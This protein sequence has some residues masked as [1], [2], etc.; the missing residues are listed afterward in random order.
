[1][2]R[3]PASAAVDSGFDSHGTFLWLLNMET[4]FMQKNMQD[5]SLDEEYL[6]QK[7]PA[8]MIIIV[9]DC[10]EREIK[11]LATDLQSSAIF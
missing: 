10:S 8:N 4:D 5:W 7:M 3:A 11:S 9:N 6:E 2:D 1:M